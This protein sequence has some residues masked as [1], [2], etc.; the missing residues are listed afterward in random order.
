[1]DTVVGVIT[2]VGRAEVVELKAGW[3]VN[4]GVAASLVGVPVV[5]RDAVVEV[6]SSVGCT[7]HGGVGVG[8]LNQSLVEGFPCVGGRTCGNSEVRGGWDVAGSAVE[9]GRRGV[10]DAG[11]LLTCLVHVSN[12]P[13]V[14]GGAASA[15]VLVLDLVGDVVEQSLNGTE[16]SVGVVSHVSPLND[17][18]LVGV[19]AL[20]GVAFAGR[21]VRVD[22]AG[23]GGNIL[24]GEVVLNGVVDFQVFNG[25]AP[26]A[27]CKRTLRSSLAGFLRHGR[28]NPTASRAAIGRDSVVE[29]RANACRT[30]RVETS[31][32]VSA[33]KDGDRHRS[34]LGMRV[35]HFG[36][37]HFWLEGVWRWCNVAHLVSDVASAGL[38]A[39]EAGAKG[40]TTPSV[41]GGRSVNHVV[42]R[43]A[44]VGADGPVEVVPSVGGD[45]QSVGRG[46]G[47]CCV[48]R[49]RTERTGDVAWDGEFVGLRVRV[50]HACRGLRATGERGVNTG[51]GVDTNGGPLVHGAVVH[52]DEVHAWAVLSGD[53]Q[54]PISVVV[55]Q[56]LVELVRSAVHAIVSIGRCGVST[57]D[58]V[59]VEGAG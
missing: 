20:E 43:C 17:E 38:S 47:L 11:T 58:P 32:W 39:V 37:D 10:S 54:V 53:L 6:G 51:F 26:L 35:L 45:T 41:R 31:S 16:L 21:A 18:D 12:R 28:G 8:D 42:G 33:V 25:G 57:S 3:D 55:P 56:V 36:V 22:A 27:G 46:R 14:V 23:D 2:V 19:A 59:T 44:S 34:A 13:R 9:T 7:G 52:E 48:E 29:G 5:G 4:V 50:G 49:E 24:S 1:M 40:E 15:V 30:A